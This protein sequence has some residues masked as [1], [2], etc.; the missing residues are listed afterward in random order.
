MKSSA[1]PGH[2]QN[3]CLLPF[4]R[5]FA[6]GQGW[7]RGIGAPL[8][9]VYEELFSTDEWKAFSSPVMQRT[10]F[11]INTI[12][13]WSSKTRSQANLGRVIEN[14]S[15]VRKISSNNHCQ[16]PVAQRYKHPKNQLIL[17]KLQLQGRRGQRDG[18]AI[19]ALNMEVGTF[20]AGDWS[21]TGPS[22]PMT[23]SQL[24]PCPLDLRTSACF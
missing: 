5:W 14:G 12:P 18:W 22:L 2:P 19:S 13:L 9:G 16:K 1:A 4:R 24:I 17:M 23:I 10:K 3:C 15:S 8:Q 7:C 6:G 11:T 20:N 21:L